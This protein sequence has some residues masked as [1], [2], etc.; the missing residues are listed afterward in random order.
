LEKSISQK[1][2][3]WEFE[4]VTIGSWSYLVVDQPQKIEPPHS[5]GAGRLQHSNIKVLFFLGV[6]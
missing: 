2:Q 1:I 4:E 6:L 3:V 5:M